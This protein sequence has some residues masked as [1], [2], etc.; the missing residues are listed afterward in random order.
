MTIIFLKVCATIG[1]Q[2]W[3]YNIN[4]SKVIDLYQPWTYSDSLF[5]TQVGGYLTTF[6]GTLSFATVHFAGHEVPAYQPERAFVIF[7]QFLNGT[8]FSKKDGTETTSSGSNDS[9][10]NSN[11]SSIIPIVIGTLLVISV[12]IGWILCLLPKSIY[13]SKTTE[14]EEVEIKFSRQ[15]DH[16]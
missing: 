2:N 9:S 15:N 16:K 13:S 5:G 4:G 12:V 1:T 10:S 7:D 6:T 8:I 14:T 11:S 3:I